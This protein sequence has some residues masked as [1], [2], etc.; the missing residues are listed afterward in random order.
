MERRRRIPLRRTP[1]RGLNFPVDYLKIDGSFIKQMLSSSV[2]R[3]M[4]EMITMTA[5]ILGMQVVAE[6]VESHDILDALKLIGVDYVQG[7][8]IGKAAPFPSL[9]DRSATPIRVVAKA[10]VRASHRFALI[11][12]DHE[13]QTR[14]GCVGGADLDVD[15]T[16]RERDVAQHDVAEIRDDPARLFGPGDP[17]H[18]A[19]RDRRTKALQRGSESV[20]PGCEQVHHIERR[21]EACD[22][23]CTVG[24]RSHHV[25]IGRWCAA[26]KNA[27]ARLDAELLRK[28]FAGMA[29]H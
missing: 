21:P 4:V 11:P 2:D 14:P 13:L 23:G 6:F 18:A 19:R 28:R 8:A 22:N 9:Q 15:Q 7:Y 25:G 26:D 27:K 16:E 1:P 10:A 29:G 24:Q 17:E 20:R 3:A 5:K 12:R